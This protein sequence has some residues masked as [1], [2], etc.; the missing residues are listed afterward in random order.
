MR[1]LRV[2]AHVRKTSGIFVALAG[3]LVVARVMQIGRAHV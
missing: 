2:N 1:R 3:L